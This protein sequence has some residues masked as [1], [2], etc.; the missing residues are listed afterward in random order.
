M[1]NPAERTRIKKVQLPGGEEIS[2]HTFDDGLVFTGIF[3][4]ER[5]VYFP[6]PA[7]SFGVDADTAEAI[8]RA[9]LAAAQVSRMIGDVGGVY[10]DSALL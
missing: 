2:I 1:S 10:P 3:A 5:S 6:G 9:Y 8:G 7:A 4:A